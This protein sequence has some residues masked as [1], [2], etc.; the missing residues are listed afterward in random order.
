MIHMKYL[1]LFS[2]KNYEKLVQNVVCCS[3]DQSLKDRDC[4]SWSVGIVQVKETIDAK[5]FDITR[6]KTN[7]RDSLILIYLKI[8]YHSTLG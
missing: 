4:F 1:V 3:C 7:N 6:Y 5:K 2:L 8:E